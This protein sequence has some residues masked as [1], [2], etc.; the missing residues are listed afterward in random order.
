[1]PWR[2]PRERGEFPTLGY[3]VGEWIEEYCI[4]PDQ[5]Q[6]GEPYLLTDEMWSHLV[7]VYRLHPD[8]VVHPRR[9]RPVD[10]H[11]HYGTQLR[12]PQK[13][14]SEERRVGKEWRERLARGVD[15]A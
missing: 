7:H 8:A 12:R 4:V 5:S 11:V 6:R 15:V 1:M 2:G 14:R 13:W 3:V 9:P 10:G